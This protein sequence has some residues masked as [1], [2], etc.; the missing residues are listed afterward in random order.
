MAAARAA[1]LAD[2][3]MRPEALKALTRVAKGAVPLRIAPV[4]R[5]T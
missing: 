4:Q 2:P 5:R 3:A 1:L